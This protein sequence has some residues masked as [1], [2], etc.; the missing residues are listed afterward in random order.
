MASSD[1]AWLSR[2]HWWSGLCAVRR[3]RWR[4]QEPA[5]GH[6]AAVTSDAMPV[7]D[8]SP[9]PRETLKATTSPR[10]SRAPLDVRAQ[11]AGTPGRVGR[12]GCH[13]DGCTAT[14]RAAVDERSS[15]GDVVV[16]RPQE[17]PR[18]ASSRPSSRRR[19][20][21]RVRR[22]VRLGT[23]APKL[24]SKPPQAAPQ[25]PRR[26]APARPVPDHP[27]P[28]M[29]GPQ[30]FA[31]EDVTMI[32]DSLARRTQ[33]P[34][35]PRRTSQGDR[36]TPRPRRSRPDAVLGFHAGERPDRA[37]LEPV[38]ATTTESR[39]QLSRPCARRL[40]R[41]PERLRDSGRR[42]SARRGRRRRSAH[43]TAAPR[44]DE[45]AASSRALGG[46]CRGP[47]A[48]AQNPSW[49]GSDGVDSTSTG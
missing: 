26:R 9:S 21:I 46:S 13:V 8:T 27:V 15:G 6:R 19:E 31:A 40:A 45:L 32:G 7:H 22:G 12:P 16:R 20:K 24:S 2:R 35:R 1:R 3:L 49:V 38:H 30:R 4:R 36:R 28:A 18:S 47:A 37:R 10:P 29:P 43:A 33:R 23:R 11:R 5:R 48:V 42:S 39:R 17:P 44:A 25:P 34:A 41:R 14:E